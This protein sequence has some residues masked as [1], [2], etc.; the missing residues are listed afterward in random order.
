MSTLQKPLVVLNLKKEPDSKSKK[1]ELNAKCLEPKFLFLDK[2]LNETK[3]KLLVVM[4]FD[5]TYIHKA[6]GECFLAL[7]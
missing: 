1:K 7:L 4:I 3:R 2:V 5:V 6:F